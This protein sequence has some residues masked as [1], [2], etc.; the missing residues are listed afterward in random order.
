MRQLKYYIPSVEIVFGLNLVLY[1]YNFESKDRKLMVLICHG[2]DRDC[3]AIHAT[4]QLKH[5]RRLV[6]TLEW[7]KSSF[8]FPW[9]HSPA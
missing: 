3:V 7:T 5:I 9:L 2:L 1:I 4:A 6:L 8:F